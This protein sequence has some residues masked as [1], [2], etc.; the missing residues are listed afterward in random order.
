[1][2]TTGLSRRRRHQPPARYVPPAPSTRSGGRSTSRSNR[3]R[4]FTGPGTASA[5]DNNSSSS[6]STAVRSRNRDANSPLGTGR[7][8]Q[9]ST[10]DFRVRLKPREPLKKHREFDYRRC[11]PASGAIDEDDVEARDM[12]VWVQRDAEGD[13]WGPPEGSGDPALPNVLPLPTDPAE[14]A[15]RVPPF[16]DTSTVDWTR[17]PRQNHCAVTDIL[18]N[19]LGPLPVDRPRHLISDSSYLHRLQVVVRRTSNSMICAFTARAA[20]LSLF[21]A[22]SVHGDDCFV[23]TGRYSV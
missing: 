23:P 10:L 6:S 17:P 16:V 19:P 22:L 9:G 21:K 8:N 2:S 11:R 7:Q 3:A 15:A 13:V 18:G 1:M 5:P 12:L 14:I 4:S 20:L